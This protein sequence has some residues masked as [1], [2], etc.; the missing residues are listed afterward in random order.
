MIALQEK[1]RLWQV[2][3]LYLKQNKNRRPKK[4]S[5]SGLPFFSVEYEIRWLSVFTL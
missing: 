4:D 5:P 2:I 3:T 1:H